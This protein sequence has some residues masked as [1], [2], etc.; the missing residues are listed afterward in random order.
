MNKKVILDSLGRD[1]VMGK[2]VRK[3]K[4]PELEKPGD[5]FREIIENIL[6]QQLSS[7]PA[8]IITKRFW[9]LF[10]K[11]PT[12]KQI[13]AMP[14]QKIRDCGTSWA[15]VKYIKSFCE[16]VENGSLDLDK[17]KELDDETVILEL[18]K[19]KGIGRWTAE[20]ILIFNLMRPD[21]FSL[22]DLGLRSAVAELYGVDRENLKV[23]GKITEKWKP[24]RS[25]ASL[26]LWQ[27]RDGPKKA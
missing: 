22:G 7:G 26:Y 18:T 5:L 14:D 15:K 27:W 12:A 6:G 13:L 2:L 23:I 8:R 24:Y 21:V 1:P 25:V 10:K 3:H 11:A 20:M 19:V 17:I 4:F 9:G 16:A